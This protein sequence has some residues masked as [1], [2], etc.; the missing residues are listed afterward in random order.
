MLLVVAG[1]F[2]RR[3]ALAVRLDGVRLLGAAAT[4]AAFLAFSLFR[5]SHA[6]PPFRSSRVQTDNAVSIVYFGLY[7]AYRYLLLGRIFLSRN[8]R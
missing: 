8:T 5:V 2:A 7:I 6:S 1:L 4:R 3:T